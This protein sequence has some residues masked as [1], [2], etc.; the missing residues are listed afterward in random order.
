MR[1]LPALALSA[2]LALA[3]CQHPDGSTDWGSTLALGAGAA[4]LV[5]IAALAANDDR[6]HD[7]RRHWHRHGGRHHR[8]AWRGHDSYRRRW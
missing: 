3:G 1:L 5:G 8:H 4:A 7:R 2:G 6:R